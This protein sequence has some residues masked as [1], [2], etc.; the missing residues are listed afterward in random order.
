MSLRKILKYELLNLARNR[1]VFALTLIVAA[2]SAGFIWMAGDFTKAVLS[3]SSVLTTLV[4]LL[5]A[6]FAV[7]YWYYSDRFTELLLTQ[8]IR[9]IELLAARWI[10]MSAS[11]I[12][13]IAV[14]ILLPFVALGGMDSGVLL[15]LAT[16]A[17][18][19]MIFITLG[20]VIAAS[21]GDRMKGIGLVLGLW[22]YFVLVHDSVILLL[23]LGFREYPLDLPAALLSA[24]NP[25]G[26]SRVLHLV[27]YDASLLLSYSGALVRSL[28]EG[29]AGVLAAV[30][31]ALLWLL[32][33]LALA[34]RRFML[35]DF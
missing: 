2:L 5:A 9:R 28:V 33:P 4:P 3:L 35:K 15:V 29:T 22:L 7:V 21:I 19:S 24:V 20:I 11:L 26:L 18:L 31:L 27:H 8:P 10:A 12:L 13:A 16:S 34:R 32:V 30:G 14:G 25:L 23:L 6:L 17:F 1:W